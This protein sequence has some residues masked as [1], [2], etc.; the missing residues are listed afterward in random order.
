MRKFNLSFI[1]KVL[2]DESGQT[3]YLLA[4]GGMMLM[5]GMG[6]LTIDVGRAYVVRTQLQGAVDA[7]ALAG[8]SGLANG[9]AANVASS[10]LSTYNTSGL[11]TITSPTPAVFCAKMMMPAGQDCTSSSLPAN[12]VQVTASAKLSTYFMKMFG[13]KTLT[14]NATATASPGE[15][16]P[17]IVEVI[18]DTTPSMKNKDNNCS[19]ATAEACALIGLQGLLSKSNPCSPSMPNCTAD[20]SNIRVGLMSF[21]NISTT[22][23]PDN[24]SGNCSGTV[25]FQQYSSPVIPAS[26]STAFPVRSPPTSRT[27]PCAPSRPS[28]AAK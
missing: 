2:G 18:L 1:R 12:A 19:A 16:K 13:V 25:A 10:F 26:T 5:L 9:Q 17:W 27:L 23:A 22:D 20:Q 11:G 7:A 14:V 24:Y 6:G 3:M 8:V 28:S 4:I 21:P 15:V